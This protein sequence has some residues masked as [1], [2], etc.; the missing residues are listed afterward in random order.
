IMACSTEGISFSMMISFP[1]D[2]LIT[3]G[4]KK[5]GFKETVVYADTNFFRVVGLGLIAGDTASAL[6][7]LKSMLVSEDLAAKLGGNPDDGYAGIMGQLLRVEDA[8]DVLI[9]GV[10]EN[11]PPESAWEYEAVLNF[12]ERLTRHTW[13]QS[14]GNFNNPMV[15]RLKPG[16]DVEQAN[17]EITNLIMNNNPWYKEAEEFANQVHMFLQPIG[18]I[19]LRNKYENGKPVGG[20]ITYVQIF[21]LVSIFLLLIACINFMNLATARSGQRA[22]EIGVRKAV[23]AHRISLIGQFLMEA[24]LLTIF[25]TILALGLVAISLPWFSELMDKELSLNLTSPAIWLGLGGLVIITSI[26]AGSYPA[27]FLSSFRT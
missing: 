4:N 19:Y 22:R 25:S 16:T 5:Q 21:T 10:F 26:L 14:W 6:D 9:T 20:R 8:R 23:G 15:V 11:L 17:Q 3:Q 13:D 27:F 1:N 24:F 18:D 12:E 2:H 7:D